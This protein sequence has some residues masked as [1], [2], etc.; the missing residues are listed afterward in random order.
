M[1]M[2]TSC[3]NVSINYN[4]KIVV[5]GVFNKQEIKSIQVPEKALLS[6]YLTIYGNECTENSDKIKCQILEALE[7]EDEC[8]EN[9]QLFLKK[10]FKNDVIKSLKLKN[11]P[12]LPY[13]S[14]IQN[15]IKKIEI[16]RN[17][18]T[19]QIVF[20]VIGMNT[21]QEKNWDIEQTERFLITDESFYKLD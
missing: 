18:D 17:K 13:K 21:S 19:M 12:N 4:H 2:M 8:N 3:N 6:G 14:A 1:V 16:S 5:N 10:W 9:H 7:I 15:K 11:C 20:R